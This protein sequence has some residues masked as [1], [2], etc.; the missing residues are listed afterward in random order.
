MDLD[1]K[2]AAPLAKRGEK[3]ILLGRPKFG[4]ELESDKCNLSSK[5][6]GSRGVVRI[7]ELSVGEA[8]DRSGGAVVID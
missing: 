6:M 1:T 8:S 7:E 2:Y 5:M 3:A 4:T